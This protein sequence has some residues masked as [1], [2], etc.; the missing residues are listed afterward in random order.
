MQKKD[1]ENAVFAV[2]LLTIMNGHAQTEQ[3]RD[4]SNQYNRAT[5]NTQCRALTGIESSNIGVLVGTDRGCFRDTKLMPCS[6]IR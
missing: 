3:T 1:Q 6:E 5:Q 2:S 4:D